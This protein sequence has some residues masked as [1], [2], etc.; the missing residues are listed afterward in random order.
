MGLKKGLGFRL[1]GLGWKGLGF[2]VWGLIEGLGLKGIGFRVWGLGFGVEGLR[3]S[4]LR[5]RL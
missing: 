5:S 2:R 4:S 3:V 1:Q